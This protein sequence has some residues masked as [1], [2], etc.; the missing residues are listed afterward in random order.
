MNK[1][2]NNLVLLTV[3]TLVTF[4]NCLPNG[5]VGDDEFLFIKNPFF[6]SWNNFPK[7]FTSQY[8][9]DQD[10][11]FND[12]TENIN[13]GSVAYRPALSVTFFLDYS[14]WKDKAF[15]YHL[16]NV[17]LHL[18]NTILVYWLMFLVLNA[19]VAALI[20]AV[21]FCVHPLKSEAVA[22]I[23][24]RADSLATLFMLVSFIFYVSPKWAG[25]KVKACS[26]LFFFL[27]LFT[28]ESVVVYP[29][30]LFAYDWLIKKEKPDDLLRS[31]WE[32]YGGYV[33]ILAFY[34]FVYFFVFPNTALHGVRDLPADTVVRVLATLWILGHYLTLFVLP[35][36][37]KQLPPLYAPPIEIGWGI[38]TVCSLTIF[39]IFALSVLYCTKKAKTHAFFLIW[40]LLAFIPVSNIIVIANPMAYR[41]M[42]LP[43]IGLAG[44]FALIIISLGRRL[45]LLSLKMRQAMLA[46]LAAVCM[47]TTVFLNFNWQSNTMMA[48]AMV[49]DFPEYPVGYMHAGMIYFNAGVKEKAVELLSRSIELGLDDPRGLYLL[50]LCSFDEP[51][52][53]KAYFLRSVREYPSYAHAYTGLG[54]I[55]LMEN[56]Y[57]EALS[58][59]NKS[60]QL[61]PNWKAYAY[62]IQL[63]VLIDSREAAVN[64]IE[65]SKG[66]LKENEVEA[67]SEVYGL[68]QKGD[69]PL[70]I[71]LGI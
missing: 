29:A 57:K 54:R 51:E 49:K 12:D 36:L 17:M 16:H 11:I 23:G 61:S 56:E 66:I 60:I 24:Y 8:N 41:F 10:A 50:A 48:L 21:L 37:V 22:S 35:P 2:K 18:I 28:K 40:F 47:I 46:G 58:Y 14:L 20:A 30:I 33:L 34:L 64:L 68:T 15:G 39:V 44:F 67:L 59:L 3:L 27:A 9:A 42:Y 65:S 6:H 63:M 1:H 26:W 32:R 19:P 13:S 25:W 45:I 69:T 55:H 38:Q 52:V 71:D 5:F 31:A 53:S 4:G 43:S 62:L 7:L 70:P